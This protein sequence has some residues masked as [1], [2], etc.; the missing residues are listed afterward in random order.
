[1]P[2]NLHN[3]VFTDPFM[4]PTRPTIPFEQ[5]VISPEHPANVRHHIEANNT[6]TFRQ[7]QT[8]LNLTLGWELEANHAPNKIPA[9]V[10]HLSDG[11]VDGDGAEF[12]VMPA[13]TKSPRY[14]LGLL[15]DLV[16]APRLNTNDSCGFHVH[17]SASNLSSIARMRQWAIATEHLALQVEDLAFKAVP[18]SRSGNSYCRRIVPLTHGTSFTS[19]KYNNGSRYHW[20]N[21]VEM[22]RPGGIRT[23]EVRLLGNTHRWKY[24]LAW[25]L[26]CMELARRGWDVANKP[27]EV[28]Q[29]VDVLGQMLIKIAKD[30]KPLE[31]KSEP[32]PQWIY[33]GLASFGIEPNAWDRPLARLVETESDLRGLPRR[34]YSDNQDVEEMSNDDENSCSCGCGNEGTCDDQLHSDGDCDSSYCER[35]HE[36]EDCSGLPSCDYCINQAHADDEDCTRR[37]CGRCHPVQ[38][39][40]N[41][42]SN[43]TSSSLGMSD[44]LSIQTLTEVCLPSGTNVMSTTSVPLTSESM[45]RAVEP[46]RYVPI[47]YSLL[48]AAAYNMIHDNMMYGVGMGSIVWDEAENHNWTTPVVI[49]PDMELTGTGMMTPNECMMSLERQ[50]DIMTD[51]SSQMM[52]ALERNAS[53]ERL[54]M[55]RGCQVG[56]TAQHSTNC[57]MCGRSWGNHF[58]HR[59]TRGGAIGSF[60]GGR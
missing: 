19:H 9:G 18:S 31:K 54:E 7:R 27:F 29:H 3:V 49:E 1:M 43:L 52:T 37:I 39:P 53:M 57:L 2:A 13:I 47:N 59:C 21:I 46:M 14:V 56:C 35:C 16:H 11:S 50:E 17:V 42:N 6:Y 41:N 40:P 8:K 36:N 28:S 32:T 30:I 24:V 58:V 34:F 55:Q 38:R 25:S 51:R 33:D 44:P 4:T 60:P 15:K 12:V 48:Q 26:F 23:I 45:R 22:F 20:L 10:E 5:S